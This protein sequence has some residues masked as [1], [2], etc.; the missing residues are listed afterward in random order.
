MG[1]AA[2]IF[3]HARSPEAMFGGSIFSNSSLF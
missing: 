3:L 2:L 1:Q